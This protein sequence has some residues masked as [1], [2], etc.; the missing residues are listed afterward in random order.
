MV[1]LEHDLMTKVPFASKI[2]KCRVMVQ[3]ANT[4]NFIHPK[5][6]KSMITSW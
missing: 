6:P 3:S 2:N 1:G 5:L 4:C